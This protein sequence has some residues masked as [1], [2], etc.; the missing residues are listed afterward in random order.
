MEENDIV[1]ILS[2]ENEEYRKLGEEHRT[3]EQL[4]EEF[5]G[6]IYLTPDEEMERKRIQK[7][8]LLKKDRMAAI[9]RDFKA[10]RDHY[11]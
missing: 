3:L 6:R 11:N 10:K 4:L 1:R 5:N 9:I 2:T 8:K 7:L